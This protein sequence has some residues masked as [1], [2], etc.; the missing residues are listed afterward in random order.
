MVL[1]KREDVAKQDFCKIL[2]RKLRLR[3]GLLLSLIRVFVG[4]S[5]VGWALIRGWA[6]INFFLLFVWHPKILHKHCLQFL[7]GVKMAPRETENNAYSNFWG[8]QTKSIMVCYG[9]F[10]SGQLQT[11]SFVFKAFIWWSTQAD[12]H[13]IIFLRTV[14][15][16]GAKGKVLRIQQL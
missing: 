7:L 6:P 13:L 11:T 9:I 12:F 1:T 15:L 10:W 3:E 14:N 2:W 5:G 8:W 4:G 16:T